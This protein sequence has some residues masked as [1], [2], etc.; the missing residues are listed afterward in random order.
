MKKVL[1]LILTL[2]LITSCTK[3]ANHKEEPINDY[4]LTYNNI[5]IKL[6]TLFSN[7]YALIGEY[8]T[9]RTEQYDNYQSNIYEY[10]F[11]EI[12]TFYENNTEK[13]YS[14]NITSNEITTNEK[15]KIGSSKDELLS[16]YGNNYK[17]IGDNIYIFT[18]NNTSIEFIV[19]NNI[20]IAIKYY[21][22]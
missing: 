10:D 12:E 11:F 1:F 13:I 20:V 14:I 4:Y 19:E 18:H 6:N 7:T 15:I 3:V 17:Q 8:N 21:K 16:T 2:L 5:D 22:E 9:N